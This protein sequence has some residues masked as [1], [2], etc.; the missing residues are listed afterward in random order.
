VY[1][2]RRHALFVYITRNILAHFK[3]SIPFVIPGIIGRN[4]QEEQR[5]EQQQQQRTQ[6]EAPAAVVQDTPEPPPAAANEAETEIATDTR[7]I[8]ATVPVTL[9]DAKE[10]CY[11]SE[12]R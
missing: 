4:L 5:Q 1:Y 3:T 10:V 7:A 9:D 11:N 2:T 12:M 6:E 8:K